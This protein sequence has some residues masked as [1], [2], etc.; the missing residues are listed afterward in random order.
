MRPEDMP[1]LPVQPGCYIFRA[2]DGRPLYVGKA[3]SLRSRVRTYFQD[4][5]RLAA[6][7]RVM[8]GHAASLELITTVSEV[9]AL[10]LES[11][12]IKKYRP[13]YN[14]VF[15]DDKTYPYLK[16]TSEDFPRLILVRR[17]VKDGGEY[18]GPYPN[19]GQVRETLRLLRRVFKLRNCS[20]Y[21][22]RT[23]HRPCL[24]YHLHRCLAPCAGLV[25]KDEYAEHVAGVRQFLR[26]HSDEVRHMLLQEMDEASQQM[27]FER[28]AELRD[29][30]R[31]L[32]RMTERQEAVRLAQV[33]EDYVGLARRGGT[34]VICLIQVRAGKITGKETFYLAATADRSDGEVIGAFLTQYYPIATSWPKTV[35]VPTLEFAD[36]PAAEAFL[37][38]G[39]AASSGRPAH[40]QVPRRG[41]RAHL[42]RRAMDN[43]ELAA[44]AEAQ[45]QDEEGEPMRELQKAL[46]LA[47]LPRR[48]EGYDISNFQGADSV[49]SMVV[50]E[51]GRPAKA[52]YRRFVIRTV[53]GADD[54]ASHAETCRRRFGR[55]LE[56][57]RAVTEGKLE[58]DKAKFARMP[59]LVL[60]DG[61]KGQLSAVRAAMREIGVD[62]IPTLGLAKQEELVFM[63]GNPEPIR[64]PRGGAALRLLQA[65]RD[66]SHR[67]AIT[68]HRRRREH[69]GL[70]SALDGVPGLGPV[71][72][73]R[74]LR[75][76]G[77]VRAVVE[78]TPEDLTRAG[79]PRN[80]AEAVY[81]KLHEHTGK[82]S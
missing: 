24:E 4:P 22:F 64:L 11:N 41:S 45:R 53:V 15:R 39:S 26:G 37:A 35:C 8:V 70:H 54:F 63:E 36:S 27:A 58:P 75:A 18:F 6:K 47:H 71:R 66:E 80:V 60:I 31:G 43:A 74:L 77:S 59:D 32:E 2:S 25:T 73:R 20:P 40:L 44:Q 1:D 3:R 72:R 50:F 69:T 13:R 55:G 67:F 61:G 56:E 16:I 82:S 38:Q 28:A 46:G 76:F 57:A 68:H 5:A 81:A 9:E 30:L 21:R 78:V 51:D 65:V 19:V 10:L 12:L 42:L 33:D 34:A 62:A 14:I 7:V 23:T 52:E 48:I 49:S 17:V 79:L 29:L